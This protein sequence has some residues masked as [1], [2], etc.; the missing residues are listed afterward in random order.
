MDATG[1]A[2]DAGGVGVGVRTADPQLDPKLLEKQIRN[3]EGYSY[4]KLD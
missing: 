1:R 2:E 4:S 3:M